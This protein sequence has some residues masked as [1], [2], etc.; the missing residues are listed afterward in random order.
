[1]LTVASALAPWLLRGS[2]VP[3]DLFGGLEHNLAVLVG[4]VVRVA[5]IKGIDGE[6]CVLSLFAPCALA[7]RTICEGV[8]EHVVLLR[9]VRCG[10]ASAA[11]PFFVTALFML[12][13]S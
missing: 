11:A 2:G 4:V 1:M 6:P 8:F 12:V 10:V 3:H 9:R 7:T 13:P 5:T